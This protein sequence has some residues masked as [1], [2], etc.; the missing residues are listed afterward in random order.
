MPRKKQDWYDQYPDNSHIQL[1]VPS[2]WCITGN[3]D[4]C[5]HVFRSGICGCECHKGESNE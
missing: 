1:S 2:G 5:Q 3:H 4:G